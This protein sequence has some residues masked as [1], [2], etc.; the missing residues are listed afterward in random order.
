MIFGLIPGYLFLFGKCGMP[1]LGIM[2]A[3]FGFSIGSWLLFFLILLQ[4]HKQKIFQKFELFKKNHLRRTFGHLK[5][6]FNIGW[7]IS[8]QIGGELILF[9]LITIFFGWLGETALAA[10]QII[11]QTNSLFLM[12]PYGLGQAG[13]VLACQYVGRRNPIKVREAGNSAFFL[14]L[15]VSAISGIIYFCFPE[16]LCAMYLVGKEVHLDTVALASQLFLILAAM[17]FFDVL[18]TIS[19]NLL[20]CFYD[21]F[22]PMVVIVFFSLIL[23]VPVCYALGFTFHFGACGILWGSVI[24]FAIS[25]IIL[26]LRWNKKLKN[27]EK[28]LKAH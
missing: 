16:K 1:K 25:S 8:V 2:G 9:S 10:R 21:T 15:L 4:V 17:Q 5:K 27:Y 23:S 20:R 13:A 19:A 18:R 12:I 22:Y 26:M 24:T 3:G 28:T 11:V 6:I 14:G 7:P